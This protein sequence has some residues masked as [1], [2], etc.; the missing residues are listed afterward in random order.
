MSKFQEAWSRHVSPWSLCL[1]QRVALSSIIFRRRKESAIKTNVN[2]LSKPIPW[3]YLHSSSSSRSQSSS[4]AAVQQCQCS[5]RFQFSLLL[6]CSAESPIAAP[7]S[8]Y[9][10]RRFRSHV[11]SSRVLIPENSTVLVALRGGGGWMLVVVVV[12]MSSIML[13]LV[14]LRSLH[15]H[16]QSKSR[17]LVTRYYRNHYL[18]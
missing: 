12:H 10:P 1:V 6:L 9:I 4:E 5:T 3:F 2:F 15:L 18:G 8:S 13:R 11:F 7:A 16:L 14:P 17:L